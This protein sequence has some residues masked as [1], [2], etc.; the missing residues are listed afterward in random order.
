MY[1]CTSFMLKI[2]QKNESQTQPS[3]IN[4]QFFNTGSIISRSVVDTFLFT[5]FISW[6]G[7]GFLDNHREARWRR[8][9]L[10]P[11]NSSPTPK[12]C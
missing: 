4:Y 11:V 2:K 1:M 7:R 8:T 6:C 5:Q 9:F 10:S 3:D 12:Y